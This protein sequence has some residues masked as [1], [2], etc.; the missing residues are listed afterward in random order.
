LDAEPRALGTGR[1]MIQ[2]LRLLFAGFLEWAGWL[3]MLLGFFGALL[4]V[5]AHLVLW[6]LPDVD[7]APLSVVVF[8]RLVPWGV[9]PMVV[10]L[11]LR[12]AGDAL[13]R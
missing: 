8:D 11:F 10:G 5:V 6:I 9:A 3:L 4:M 13:N 1:P 12:L 2:R 7:G